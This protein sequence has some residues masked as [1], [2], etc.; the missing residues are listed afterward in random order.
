MISSRGLLLFALVWFGG[1]DSPAD[2]QVIYP[3][4]LPLQWSVEQPG[5]FLVGYRELSTTYT[6]P[7]GG[8]SRTIPVGIWYPTRSRTDSTPRYGNW[9][10]DPETSIDARPAAPPFPG[11]FP[12]LVHSH[13]DAAFPGSNSHVIR[14]LVSHG[15]AV[16]EPAHVGNTLDDTDTTRPHPLALYLWR[17]L[18]VRAALDLA[19]ALP[20]GDPL[21]GK[22]DMS[23]VAMS[24]H[25]FG[26]YTAWAV[27]GTRFSLDAIRKSCD[28]N[29]VSD[30]SDAL[31]QAFSGD[32]SE[33]R[34]RV[35][36]PMAGGGSS[37]FGANPYDPLGMP[38]LLMEGSLNQSGADQLFAA[39]T[40]VDFTWVNIEGGCHELFNLGNDALGD[41][42][43]DS[44]G[45]I[46]CGAL[47]SEAGFAAVNSWLLAYLRSHLFD[48]HSEQ[49]EAIVNNTPPRPLITFH[50]R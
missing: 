1:C 50:R 22:L 31:I 8:A 21:A 4:N 17:P 33:R 29:E 2:D 26:T 48:D 13:G 30:C 20:A 24:G 12:V 46:P 14:Y 37:Y 19:A 32:L 10:D 23:R 36:V 38:L 35:I 3:P 43:N 7:G 25:S 18:D 27:S 47:P 49:V 42:G 44:N 5:A 9:I 41:H 28:K 34:A 15:W 6:P 11:G 39:T 16:I 40:G 45:A